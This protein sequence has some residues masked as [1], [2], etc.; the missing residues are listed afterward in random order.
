ML[1]LF[2]SFALSC[3]RNGSISSSNLFFVSLSLLP[4]HPPEKRLTGATVAD[5]N[6]LERRDALRGHLAGESLLNFVVSSGERGPR[7]RQV[8]RRLEKRR[9]NRLKR[10]GAPS[11][12]VVV[13]DK[14]SRRRRRRRA[15]VPAPPP[16]WSVSSSSEQDNAVTKLV[17]VDVPWLRKTRGEKKKKKRKKG[18]NKLLSRNE[19]KVTTKRERREKKKKKKRQRPEIDGE[20]EREKRKNQK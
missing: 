4:L 9:K 20:R 10:E 14:Q 17:A 11:S 12:F 15:R 19:W 7:K 5:Q 6:E 16:R 8:S 18:R 13:D 2:F 3:R 1:S